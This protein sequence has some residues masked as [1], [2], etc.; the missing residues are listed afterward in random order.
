LISGKAL[1]TAKV[2]RHSDGL[3]PLL[4]SDEKGGEQAKVKLTSLWAQFIR[5]SVGKAQLVSQ[6]CKYMHATQLFNT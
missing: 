6:L 3:P 5:P 1:F 2:Q 4:E